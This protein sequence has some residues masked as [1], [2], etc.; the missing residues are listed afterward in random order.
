[1]SDELIIKVSHMEGRVPVAVIHVV[2]DVDANTHQALDA[3]VDEVM[4]AGAENVLLDLTKVAYM[5]SAG[6][7]SMHRLHTLTGEKGG[8]VK[9]LNPA[10]E[11]KRL[12]KAMGF[13]TEMSAHTDLGQAI[14]A[15]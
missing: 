8:V 4:A 9:L 10:D 13:D 6:F 12:M 7:R 1:M 11:V 5:S 3:K 15:F 14:D 2:G